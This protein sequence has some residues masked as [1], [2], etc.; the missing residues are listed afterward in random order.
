MEKGIQVWSKIGQRLFPGQNN[1]ITITYPSQNAFTTFKKIYSE[2]L[3]H[4]NFKWIGISKWRPIPLF[5]K[6]Y[7]LFYAYAQICMV[8]GTVSQVREVAN[9]PLVLKRLKMTFLKS[10]F[11][12]DSIR[13][14]HFLFTVFIYNMSW[15]S[16]A[17]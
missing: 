11:L 1:R 5:K 10:F 17:G 9:R 14:Y 16:F 7:H 15:N 12:I 6:R 13:I 4:P 8:L 2:Q 3:D